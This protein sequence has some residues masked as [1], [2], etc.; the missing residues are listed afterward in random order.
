MK[1][2][3]YLFPLLILLA[4]TACNDWVTDLP[5]TNDLITEDQMNTQ[6]NV[7]FMITGLHNRMANLST[8]WLEADGISDQLFFDQRVGNSTYSTYMEL[9]LATSIQYNNSASFSTIQLMRMNA[10]TLVGRCLYKIEFTNDATGA[11]VKKDGLF[12]G[13]LYGGLA[14]Y[15]LAAYIGIHPTVGGATINGG[16][17]IPSATL[18]NQAIDKL[19]LALAQSSSAYYTKLVNSLIAKTYFM[20]GDYA[21]A[22]T[23]INQG[24]VS[25][26]SPFQSKYS[27]TT[28]E[29]QY[30]AQAGEA[31]QQWAVDLRFVDYITAVPDEAIR[32]PLVKKTNGTFVY[33]RQAKY[34]QET[35]G[36]T[37]PFVFMDWQ[38]NSMMKAEIMARQGSAGNMALINAIRTS[39]GMTTLVTKDLTVDDIYV[40][41]DK[42]LFLRGM[43]LLDEKRFNKPHIANMWFYIPISQNEIDKNPNLVL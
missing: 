36:S 20:A 10:D 18:Y 42:E 31:R 1:K 24:L 11:Q 37:S 7:P 15:H 35:D 12:W 33:Y 29:N 16:A 41:R 2:I 17:F 27:A 39:R 26:D 40:E 25:G 19:K 23:Y 22:L 9:D 43:R 21:N 5:H 14:R 13:Y 6:V 4:F 34:K 28:S 3:K 32:L 8:I 38:E 30:R